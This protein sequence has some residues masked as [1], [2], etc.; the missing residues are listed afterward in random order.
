MVPGSRDA[1]LRRVQ[2]SAQRNEYIAESIWWS[3]FACYTVTVA[4]ISLGGV[5]GGGYLYFRYVLPA[6]A[7]RVDPTAQA[8][9][10][11]AYVFVLFVLLHSVV[12]R[13]RSWLYGGG[14]VSG[15]K[16]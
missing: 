13:I 5:V 3:V 16:R 7:A 15:W 1:L 6:V 4:T 12:S 14:T 2:R 11:L 10:G 8:V 9:V